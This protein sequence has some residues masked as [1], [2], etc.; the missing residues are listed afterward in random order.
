MIASQTYEA[1]R[2][3]AKITYA[4]GV[5]TEFFYAAERRWLIRIVT[6]NG[7][8]AA[9][10]DSSYSRDTAGRIYAINGLTLSD[11]WSYTYDDLDRLTG[12][13]NFGDASLTEAFA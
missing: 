6:R 1:D 11:T 2:Q 9:L 12:A 10:I 13:Q 8:C 5:S 7:S 4:N 3:T